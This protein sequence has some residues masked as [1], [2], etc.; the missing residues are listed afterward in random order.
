M[1]TSPRILAL[2]GAHIDRRGQV[3][4]T[5]VPAASN[6][7][8]M[9][10]D[11]GGG[12]F[13]ALRSVVKRGVSA[14]LLSVRGGDAAAETVASAIAGAGIDDLSVVFLDRTTPSYTALID[15]EGELIVGFADMGLYDLAF[16]KQ[17]RRAKVREAIAGVDAIL[18]DANLPTAALERLVAQAGG[19]PLFAIAISPAKVVRLA[20]LLGDLS[21]LFM[22]R[23]E[24]AALAG[25]DMSGRDLVDAVKRLGLAAG[26]I[27]AGSAPVLGF[28]Q[29][30][31]FA[32]D[33]P[34]PRQVADVTGAGDA[35]TGATV[36]ALLRG[37]PLRAAL[38]EGVAAAMLAIESAEAVPSFTAAGFAQELALVPEAREVA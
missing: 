11:V 28:D 9:R 30:G 13:N 16:P 25:A 20:P 18:C 37:L 5:Y 32:I 24:A 23:R 6:P 31:V 29:S 1:P 26:V 38:R 17:I 8:I 27:T 34:A 22:N 4:G 21:L 12:V 19:R 7:G 3:S 36:A 10:E 33:P 2:G 35:L 15:T 14:S